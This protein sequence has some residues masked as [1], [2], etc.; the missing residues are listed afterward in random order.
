[1]SFYIGNKGES[2]TR[3]LFEKHNYIVEPVDKKNRDFYD[4]TLSKRGRS[5]TI[6]VKFDVKSRFT[7]NLAIEFYNTKQDKD[8]GLNISKADFF[9]YVVPIR[10]ITGNIVDE[11]WIANTTDLRN[12]TT[13][14]TGRFVSGAGD[15]NA[16]IG[17]YPKEK[18]LGPVFKCIS[19]LK[20]EHIDRIILGFNYSEIYVSP[21]A[22][23]DILN[24]D[25]EINN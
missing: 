18:L 10:T 9:V 2:L 7:G 23:K 14:V 16:Y 12:F 20:V 8:S 25:K 19:Y 4:M 6:E 22:M 24:W 5:R 21:E 1:M 17:L 3:Q 11:I 13:T 15:N